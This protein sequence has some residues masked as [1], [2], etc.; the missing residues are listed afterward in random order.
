MKKFI[1][2]ISWRHSPVFVSLNWL[3]QQHKPHFLSVHPVNDQSLQLWLVKSVDNES[4]SS[5]YSLNTGNTSGWTFN[6]DFVAPD[7]CFFFSRFFRFFLLLLSPAHISKYRT[8]SK[9]FFFY[10]SEI[11]ISYMRRGGG[12][13]HRVHLILGICTGFQC[14]GL[15]FKNWRRGKGQYVTSSLHQNKV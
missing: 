11:G 14:K 8:S 6:T 15:N 4:F 3:Y 1:A 13:R 10:F 12:R 9:I 2:C 7:E 5:I